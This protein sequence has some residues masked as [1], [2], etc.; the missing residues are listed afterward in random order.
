[1][2]ATT[3]EDNASAGRPKMETLEVLK[4]KLKDQFLPYNTG[5]IAR[6]SLKKLKYTGSVRDYVK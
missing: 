3:M 1:M 6:E 4:K 5:W 2:V